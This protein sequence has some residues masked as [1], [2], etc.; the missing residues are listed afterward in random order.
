MMEPRPNPFTSF[1]GCLLSQT[2][3]GVLCL[4]GFFGGAFIGAEFGGM[5]NTVS[6]ALL[7]MMLLGFVPWRRWLVRRMRARQ[8]DH[9]GATPPPA[10]PPDT[11]PPPNDRLEPP[12]PSS[13]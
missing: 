1:E 3:W 10:A 4:L 9:R 5:Q 13:P 11:A 2:L 6:G 7:G 8:P 12:D